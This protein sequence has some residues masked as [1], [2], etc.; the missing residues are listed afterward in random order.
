MLCMFFLIKQLA[1]T[2]L[3]ASTLSVWIGV[4]EE[5]WETVWGSIFSSYCKVSLDKIA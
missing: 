1:G 5:Y 3:L 2:F 4:G